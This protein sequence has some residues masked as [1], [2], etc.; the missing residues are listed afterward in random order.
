MPGTDLPRGEL[1]RSRSAHEPSSER[2]VQAKA[3]LGNIGARLFYLP[4]DIVRWHYS[5]G[6]SL[7]TPFSF[8]I[9]AGDDKARL[10]PIV[11]RLIDAGVALWI[12]DPRHPDLKLAQPDLDRLAGF[13]MPGID[14]PQQRN[15]ALQAA[16]SFLL[17]VS[18]ASV[19]PGRSQVQME[20]AVAEFREIEAK[21]PTYPIPLSQRELEGGAALIGRRQGFKLYVEPGADGFSLTP[22]GERDLAALI[23]TILK[24]HSTAP[25]GVKP[26]AGAMV[27]PY[28]A[29]RS[30]Q[31]FDIADRFRGAG[32]VGRNRLSLPILLG[33]VEDRPDK[34]ALAQLPQRVLPR[35]LPAP[36]AQ[37][38]SLP[39]PHCVQLNPDRALRLFLEEFGSADATTYPIIVY[40]QPP[41]QDLATPRGVH[42]CLALWCRI[43]SELSASSQDPVFVPVLDIRT[44]LARSG[45]RFGWP[46]RRDTRVANDLRASVA[47]L[48]ASFPHVEL[49]PSTPLGPVTWDCV[50]TWLRE[51]LAPTM[52][53]EDAATV[54]ARLRNGFGQQGMAMED[55]AAS[56]RAVIAALTDETRERM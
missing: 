11:R 1:L 44:D 5:P 35:F 32:S 43:W 56:A 48:E 14:W 55:W 28:F 42:A 36:E 9:H 53:E 26:P 22:R 25:P 15:L 30:A 21:V 20:A 51:E 17:S 49:Y 50:E 46:W 33:A 18:A 7:K 23:E 47:A 6:D 45:A 29:D 3:V 12:D 16:S 31:C 52:S 4:F 41:G 13:V 19:H 37:I 34:F 2:S 27:S 54:R 40:A 39:W 8:L 24:C 38:V 10:A